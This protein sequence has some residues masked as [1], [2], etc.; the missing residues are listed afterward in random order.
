M[1]TL[2]SD[3][4]TARV[5][6]STSSSVWGLSPPVV[7]IAPPLSASRR[8]HARDEPLHD[9]VRHVEARHLA[10]AVLDD[11]GDL[12]IAHLRLPFVACQVGRADHR[13]ELPVS[14]AGRAVAAR[15][16]LAPCEVD[17]ARDLI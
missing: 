14:P 11:A 2:V 7:V 12:G 9:R 16:L 3:G 10:L 13:A 4:R 15:A 5:A 6:I 17:Q 8:A 1:P